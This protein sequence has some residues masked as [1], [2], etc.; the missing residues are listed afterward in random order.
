M[1]I[2]ENSSSR[3]IIE[4]SGS[5][6]FSGL[7]FLISVGCFLLSFWL[8]DYFN[9]ANQELFLL[10]DYSSIPAIIANINAFISV[11]TLFGAYREFRYY[12]LIEFS[13]ENQ[14]VNIKERGIFSSS[15]K[16]LII[17]EFNV[18]HSSKLAFPYFF[19][20]REDLWT[21]TIVENTGRE[22]IVYASLGLLAERD[23]ME[24]YRKMCSLIGWEAGEPIKQVDK[25][26]CPKCR[27][28][29]PLNAKYCAYCGSE[30][31]EQLGK[32]KYLE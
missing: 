21:I 31:P 8:Y 17:K 2:I 9:L 23:L 12:F 4:E 10:L 18:K 27:E 6:F 22:Y 24:L 16:K 26:R 1:K 3:V 30:I 25:V 19:S 13:G 7:L 28:D 15:E 11:G 29:I 32:I 5:K 14:A 20:A